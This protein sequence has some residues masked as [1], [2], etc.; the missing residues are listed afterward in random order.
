MPHIVK[1]SPI[2]QHARSSRKTE[3]TAIK[4]EDD[5]ISEDEIMKTLE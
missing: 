4:Q 5:I 1:L 2:M 3:E